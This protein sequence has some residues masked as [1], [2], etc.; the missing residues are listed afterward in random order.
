MPNSI[1]SCS[2]LSI[3]SLFLCYT[4]VS[5][6]N[7]P[8]S[9]AAQ[10][11]TVMTNQAH[12]GDTLTM[13]S[14][15][16]TN[17]VIQF[18]GN[19]TATQPI[20][21]R[22]QGGYGSVILT[23]T[24]L[25]KIGG[26]YLIVDGL[27][28][29]NGYSSSDAVIEFRNSSGTESNY[30]RL[31][32]SA[33]INYNPASATTDYKWI[34][35]YGTHNRVDHCYTEGKSHS[36]TT[37]VVWRPT[38]AA[39]YHLIDHNYFGPRPELGVNGGETIRVGTSDQSLSSS[40]TTVEY[41]YFEACNGE[42][43]IISNKSCDNIYRYN[44]FVNC[45]GT[46]TLRHGNRC[47]VEGN[48]FFGNG[49]SNTGG[50]RIIGEDH[51][52]INN[53]LTG[54]TGDGFRT[55]IS[56]VDG[57]VNSPLNGYYQVKRALVA[58]NTI[59]SNAHSIEFGSGKDTDNILPPIDCIVANNLIYGTQSPLINFEDTPINL[60]WQKNIFYGAS[61]GISPT[62]SG[63]TITDPKLAPTG[64]D[65]LRHLL[66]NS[67]AISASESTYTTVVRDMDGQLR[68]VQKD[69]GADEYS[70][71]PYTLKPLTPNDVGP[72]AISYTI[73]VTQKSNGT[74]TPGTTSV[75]S[76]NTQTYIIAP[77][78][79]YHVDSVIVDGI[80]V[81][82]SINSYTF[83]NVLSNHSLYAIFSLPKYSI[84]VHSTNGTVAK[85]PNQ[86]TYDSNTTVQLTATP[87]TGYHFV[88]WSGDAT[89]TSN[90]LD[91]LMN[92]NKTITATFAINKYNL[93]L[94]T[95][96]SGNTIKTPDQVEYD[97]ASS[98]ILNAEP[99]SGW[100]F[101]S[102]IGDTVTTNNPITIKMFSNKNITAVFTPNP[103]F[104]SFPVRTGWNLCSLP[105]RH[106][107]N[108]VDSLFPTATTP[109]FV[110]D[111]G[112]TANDTITNG[113]GFWIKFSSDESLSITGFPIAV[114]TIEVQIGWNMIGTI[115]NPFPSTNI[116]TQP[117]G[118]VQSPYFFFDETGYTAGDTLK[119]GVGYWVK[120]NASGKL[121]IN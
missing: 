41:N 20:L 85:S 66:S 56:L 32:N 38:T 37:L 48:F 76:G 54:L 77:N 25:L 74:I 36:G 30:C 106:T 87:N 112:Y 16:W 57:I 119:P 34:S 89:G 60:K 118:L 91:V 50:I 70:S 72:N 121:L 53:Y 95:E 21:L 116:V 94:N 107:Q 99:V 44:T 109:A 29:E 108:R 5:A 15:T 120:T 40:Y 82:D 100:E 79:G 92:G 81:P 68:D 65:G 6:T 7:F 117:E 52:V 61:L 97:Y 88:N 84:T 10:I 14:G 80:N 35:I 43:E 115:T 4:Q 96:G 26:N 3:L 101:S 69:V 23:G 104:F 13:T 51:V 111:R 27:K 59:V 62:P 9:T 105:L 31:T 63:I 110:F 86:V 45:V 75:F 18:K 17:Q 55:A 83:V 22:S 46:L 47:R 113:I 24:S 103:I 39:N 49:I 33:V 1:V 67:P 98:V 64:S 90:P 58:F 114:D 78:S 28:F 93:N 12:P 42:T 19:G 8:V 102:W 11:T 2:I 71:A 73:T